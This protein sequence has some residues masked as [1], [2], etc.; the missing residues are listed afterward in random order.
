MRAPVII[1]KLSCVLTSL[2]GLVFIILAAILYSS[3]TVSAIEE[4]IYPDDDVYA[5]PYGLDLDDYLLWLK[6]MLIVAS[7]LLIMGIVG[8]CGVQR[9]SWGM[10]VAYLL[11][12]LV[13]LVFW[14]AFVGYMFF[15]KT[16]WKVT[17]KEE[18]RRLWQTMSIIDEEAVKQLETELSCCG[19]SNALDYCT[20]GYISEIMYSLVKTQ[21]LK[22]EMRNNLEQDD[23][24]LDGYQ[25]Y[26]G[27]FP[28]DSFRAEDPS[29]SSY[30][31]K[32]PIIS[33]EKIVWPFKQ[34]QEEPECSDDSILFLFKNGDERCLC[35]S[36]EGQAFTPSFYFDQCA[37]V[38]E[39]VKT[40][41]EM[42][43]EKDKFGQDLCILN[44]CGDI[45]GLEP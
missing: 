2:M 17:F 3:E 28:D 40:V 5:D 26:E 12:Q 33:N 22:K 4:L 16:E 35:S 29:Y 45:I 30:S 10:V 8:F 44:G 36:F 15:Y 13:W 38:N 25:L 7:G 31:V 1:V 21:A 27:Y 42:C 34:K 23:Y 32:T 9:Y 14:I 43:P 39:T 41:N 19:Y 18:S 6:W 24:S 11:N 37:M 20:A